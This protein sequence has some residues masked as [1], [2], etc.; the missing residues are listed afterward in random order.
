MGCVV[1]KTC[2]RLLDNE[3]ASGQHGGRMSTLDTASSLERVQVEPLSYEHVHEFL[4]AVR[5]SR[6]LH[7][8][9]VAPPDSELSFRAYVEARQGP[10]SYGYVVRVKGQL[11]GTINLNGVM[12][13]L[14]QSAFLGY[15]G[16]APHEQ[17]G[18]MSEA[19]NHVVKI[20]FQRHRLH[21][22]EA[23]IQ[24]DNVRSIAL[25]KRTGFRLEG[26]SPRY[27]K[28]AGRWR[29]HERWALTLEDWRKGKSRG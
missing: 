19:L 11:A 17:R 24:P 10:L 27:L 22:L 9:W 29:D 23:N 18:Y 13:G 16:F 7:G 3:R 1:G 12:R 15:Y 28:I 8:R 14:L 5:R 20:A 26:Y 25:I 2:C 21:R 6:R 4:A